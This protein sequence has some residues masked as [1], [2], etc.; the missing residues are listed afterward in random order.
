MNQTIST[1]ALK[2]RNGFSLIEVAIV[3]IVVAILATISSVG[4]TTYL[5]DSRDTERAT[6]ISILVEALEKYYDKN[7]EY[8]SCASVSNTN[9]ASA[10][11]V[12][13]GI[14]EQTFMAPQTDTNAISCTATASSTVDTFTYIATPAVPVGTAPLN[15]SLSYWGEDANALVTTKSRR[16]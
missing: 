15:Y 11:A 14:D 12:L 7:G 13:G 9:L 1:K 5:R 3:I 4:M 6:K 2:H 16:G 10:A 8:P